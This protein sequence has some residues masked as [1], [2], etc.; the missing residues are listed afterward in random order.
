[1]VILLFGIDY[2]KLCTLASTIPESSY[3]ITFIY[4]QKLFDVLPAVENVLQG[5]LDVT[6]T[7][8]QIFYDRNKNLRKEVW[9]VC[10]FL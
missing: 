8:L 5:I 9:P 10:I 7:N 6:G 1:L 4:Y 3:T 2:S